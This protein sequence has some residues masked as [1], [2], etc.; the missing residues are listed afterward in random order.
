MFEHIITAVHY[1]FF[2]DDVVNVEKLSLSI[3]REKKSVCLFEFPRFFPSFHKLM[4]KL[5]KIII[6]QPG[7]SFTSLRE[8]QKNSFAQN[9]SLSLSHT[10][11]FGFF[12]LK[13]NSIFSSLLRGYESGVFNECLSNFEF[14]VFVSG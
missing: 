10:F 4:R 13:F 5:K 12:L 9:I 6:S 8:K 7:H 3:D 1:F 2:F 11:N 14:L